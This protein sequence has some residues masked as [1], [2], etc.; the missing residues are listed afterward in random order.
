MYFARALSIVQ[1][2]PERPS[3][4]YIE[5]LMLLV[6][7]KDVTLLYIAMLTYQALFSFLLDRQ[8][9]GYILI[10]DAVRYGVTIGLNHNIPESQ[11]LDPIE[12]EHRVR[13]W[14]TMYVF[15]RDWSARL[16]FPV[17]LHDEGISASSTLICPP[18]GHLRNYTLTNLLKT[19]IVSL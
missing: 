17:L 16:S 15:D 4:T 3:I 12:R 6:R 11:V 9:C 1:V 7:S 19:P 18:T 10:S 2:R 8:H 5:T 13:L 14:W